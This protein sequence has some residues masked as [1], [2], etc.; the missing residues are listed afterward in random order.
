MALYVPPV[1]FGKSYDF[2]PKR[3]NYLGQQGWWSVPCGWFMRQNADGTLT[4]SPN[5]DFSLPN[6]DVKINNDGYGVFFDAG[7]NTQAGLMGPALR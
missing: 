4:A 7:R 3:W 2:T 6:Y 1:V 5:S